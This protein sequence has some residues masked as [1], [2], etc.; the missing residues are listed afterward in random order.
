MNRYTDRQMIDT[1][2]LQI[3]LQFEMLAQSSSYHSSCI[4][5][6][7][8]DRMEALG[9]SPAHQESTAPGLEQ[10]DACPGRLICQVQLP[11]P[12]QGLKSQE[13]YTHLERRHSYNQTK[14]SE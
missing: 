11:G 13:T 7:D 3:Y 4:S 10:S 5:L 12:V 1:D 9:E 6:D 2:L 8:Q 14:T